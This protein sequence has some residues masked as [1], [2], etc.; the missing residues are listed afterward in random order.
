MEAWAVVEHGKPLEKIQRSIPEPQGTEVLVK[1]THCGVCHSDLHFWEG[2]Y[3]LGGGH[4][5]NI[6]DRGVKLPRAVGHEIAGVVAKLGPDVEGVA[7]GDR[8]IVYP[9]VGCGKC[10]RC[11]QEQ[12]NL[13]AAQRSLG[14]A[15]DGGFA[16]YV[17]VPHAKYLVDVGDVDL[18]VACTFGCSGITV[19][20]AI[21]K[22]MPLDADDAIILIGAGGLGLA[23]I[24]M[25]LGL[26][27]RNIISLDIREEKR[28]A[29]REAGAKVVVD[30]TASD[31]AAQVSTAAGGPIYGIL[32]F[33]N[34]SATALLAMNLLGKGGRM[35]QVGVLGGELKLSL[36][37]MI[38]KAATISFNNTGNLSHLRQ[39]ARLATEGKLRPLPVTK[40][41][42]DQA[43]AALTALQEGKVVGRL[44]LTYT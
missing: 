12:D 24:S 16:S 9:W 34:N 44:V 36:V 17:L 21:Q 41:P 27:H 32:D 8:R 5:F 10:R 2:S 13:C 1:V 37:G 39:V 7:K 6:S 40:I 15:Q 28:Q 23:A 4:R 38:F 31:A 22:V 26:G 35:V 14:V 43:N 20:S 33:V 30:S 29:A 3:D 42:A 25:L 11:Q 19:L 18:A